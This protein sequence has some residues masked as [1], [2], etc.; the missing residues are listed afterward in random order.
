MY[1]IL[2][3]TLHYLFRTASLFPLEGVSAKTVSASLARCP[4]ER[5]E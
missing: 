3:E 2:A 4:S 1:F 5:A